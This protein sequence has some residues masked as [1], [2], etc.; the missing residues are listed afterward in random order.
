MYIVSLQAARPVSEDMLTALGFEAGSIQTGAVCVYPAKVP[1]A[2]ATLKKMGMY[3]KINVA[4]G[5]LTCLYT[6]CK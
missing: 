4:S 2:V 6:S 1:I 3:N 5:N